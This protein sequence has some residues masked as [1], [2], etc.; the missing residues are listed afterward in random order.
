[1]ETK[2]EVEAQVQRIYTLHSALTSILARSVSL[3]TDY[4]RLSGPWSVRKATTEACVWW[5]RR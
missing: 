1:M 3:A 2:L 4:E 5:G